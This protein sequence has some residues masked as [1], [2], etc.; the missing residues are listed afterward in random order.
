M[1]T[2]D[3]TARHAKYIQNLNAE[4]AEIWTLVCTE[5][6]LSHQRNNRHRT[7][8]NHTITNNSHT[9]TQRALLGRCRRSLLYADSTQTETERFTDGRE[10]ALQ[11]GAPQL[12]AAAAVD[13]KA[14][15][16]GREVP[17][18]T[19]RDA[20]EFA[21]PTQR[22]PEAAQT[23]QQAVAARLTTM[24]TPANYVIRGV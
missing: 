16:T 24:E 21:A 7:Y 9:A 20:G 13:S 22:E 5:E 17:D 3:D 4:T 15:Q 8:H 23:R 1:S 2:S 6:S 14:A 18:V 12:L 19:E 11:A 10:E